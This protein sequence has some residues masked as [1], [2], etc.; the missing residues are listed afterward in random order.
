MGAVFCMRKIG[1]SSLFLTVAAFLF[2]G[3][4]KMKKTQNITAFALTLILVLTLMTACTPKPE[5]NTFSM[6]GDFGSGTVT[7]VDKAPV[8]FGA[9]ATAF[10]VIKSALIAK[11]FSYAD[12]T[13]IHTITA[14]DGTAYAAT[15]VGGWL[16][17]VNGKIPD[18]AAADYIVAPGDHVELRFVADYNTDVDWT[19][20]TFIG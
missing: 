13:Y 2:L 18:V 16:F 10:D 6:A 15:D 19:M 17:A 7:L 14:S 5:A 12:D 1:R 20:G 8:N 11:D 4:K 3:G 9:D